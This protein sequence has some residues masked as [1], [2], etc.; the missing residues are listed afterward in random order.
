MGARRHTLAFE[1]HQP[2]MV[3]RPRIAMLGSLTET[4][5][6]LCW[7]SFDALPRDIKQPQCQLRCIISFFAGLLIPRA[8]DGQI[9]L[10][11]V[12][13]RIENAQ[14]KFGGGIALLGR[15]LEQSV[16]LAF[17]FRQA[18]A[19]DLQGVLTARPAGPRLSEVTFPARKK[20]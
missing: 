16:R 10:D 19:T 9:D 13:I 1:R 20:R 15:Q 18:T 17:V 8:G 4:F 2:E 6:G 12:T 14:S 7:I 11:T 5:D 3:L